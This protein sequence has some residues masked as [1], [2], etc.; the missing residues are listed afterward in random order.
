MEQEIPEY[1]Y[2][3]GGDLKPQSPT[4]VTRQA[5]DELYKALSSGELCYLLNSRQMGKS[6]MK[7][8]TIQRLQAEGVV[9]CAIDL[10]GMG[11]ADMNLEKWY[12]GILYRLVK[13]CGLVPKFNW[14]EWWK[15]RQKDTS[16]L[17]R[18]QEFIEE[19][20]L[21]EIPQKIVVFID[22][23]D[24]VLRQSFSLDDF[25]GL[26]RF[27]YNQRAANQQYGYD[28]L[29]FAL[30]GVATPSELIDDKIRS[31]FNVG[32]AI[33]LQGFKLDEVEPLLQGLRGI[34]RDP[35]ALMQ[36]ILKWT[37]GQPFLT[38]K[39]C[40]LALAQQE[41]IPPGQEATW[42]EQ[43]VKS[44]VIENWESQ[45]QPE[46]LRSI[47]DHVIYN[48]KLK[49]WFLSQYQTILH[50]GKIESENSQ[51][52]MQFRLTGLVI[53]H[54]NIL[55]VYNQVYKLVFKEDWAS[56]ELKNIRPYNEAFDK[57]ETSNYHPE[58]LLKGEELD[59]ALQWSCDIKLDDRDYRYL[60]DSQNQVL[61]ETKQK[62]EFANE[63]LSKVQKEVKKSKL[64]SK[65]LILFGFFGAVFI[66]S[67]SMLSNFVGW[68]LAESEQL[69]LAKYFFDLA[70]IA[71]PKNELAVFQQGIVHI[72]LKDYDQAK[73][74]FNSLLSSQDP[75]VK[76]LSYSSL[77]YIYIHKGELSNSPIS[78]KQSYEEAKK[79][80][81]KALSIYQGLENPSNKEELIHEK[82]NILKNLAWS[83]LRLEEYDKAEKNLREAIDSN[84]IRPSAYCL[85]AQVIEKKEKKIEKKSLGS[86]RKCNELIN[87]DDPKSDKIDKEEWK[88]QAEERLL[89]AQ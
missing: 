74:N 5:D 16:P 35:L 71:N 11:V 52:M 31:P 41:S 72:N 13:D 20:L 80:S 79:N 10:Q 27:C 30:L 69:N 47:R 56:T 57:W 26:I 61:T 29:T 62:E 40:R 84:G 63:K 24:S 86:W 70:L 87:S 42:V 66:A 50:K 64:Q 1:E 34:A 37:S 82:Y 17:Q 75:K 85:M 3:V 12:M 65:L 68:N 59:E 67:S 51:E 58:H 81:L 33:E 43:L 22:E 48:K 18:L 88:K 76:S 19:V 53:K 28:R 89:S 8:R 45:D 23:V 36:E 25:F 60:A 15:A 9:C 39:I 32:R 46:H 73:E 21:V 7:I 49:L 6:S 55:K 2:V 44:K 78:R 38:Q 77:S 83:Q 4:Y 54:G 14:R